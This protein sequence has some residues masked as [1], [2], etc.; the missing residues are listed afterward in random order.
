MMSIHTSAGATHGIGESAR[1]ISGGVAIP[2]GGRQVRHCVWLSAVD[3]ACLRW[4]RPVYSSS[5]DFPRE[6]WSVTLAFSTEKQVGD[7]RWPE[8]EATNG[9]FSWR[10]LMSGWANGLADKIRHAVAARRASVPTKEVIYDDGWTRVFAPCPATDWFAEVEYLRIPWVEE[11]KA[12]KAAEGAPQ[13]LVAARATPGLTPSTASTQV[14]HRRPVAV[15]PSQVVA[16]DGASQ[17]A[18]DIIG[19]A[20]RCG[21]HLRLA[22]HGSTADAMTAHC[23]QCFS[24]Q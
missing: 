11:A 8:L 24:L 22:S 1:S 7:V 17:C 13:Q 20:C 12:R 15:R 16:G 21:A 4:I 5:R 9:P 14:R 23:P 2:R 18:A 19:A 6:R 10:L 3:G